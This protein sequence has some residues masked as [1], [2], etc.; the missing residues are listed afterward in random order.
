MSTDQS[1][2]LRFGLALIASSFFLS[3]VFCAALRRMA[4]RWGLLDRPGGH[5]GHRVPTPLGGGVAIWLAIMIVLSACG[6][7]VL[8]GPDRLPEAIARHAGGLRQRAGELAW[9]VGLSTV[10]MV[11]GFIDD[12]KNLHWKPRLAIQVGCAAAV[13][14]AAGVRI[15]LFGPFTHPLLGGAVTVLWIVALTNAFNMLDNMDG[16]A[17]SVGLIAALIFGAAQA[18]VG[19]LFAPAVLL[20]VVGA[21]AGF[22]VHN[23]APARLFMGDA[24]SNF[25]GFLL[26]SLTVAGS[27]FHEG[28]ASPF[29]VLAPLLVMAVPLYDMTSVILIR[30]S[31]GRSPFQGDRRHFSHRLVARGLTPPQ[32]VWTIDLV[33]LACGLGAL[34]LHRLDAWGAGLVLAQ[35]GCLLGIVAILEL[36]GNRSE[37]TLGH[38]RRETAEALERETGRQSD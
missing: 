9:I 5:K 33:T 38:A 28:V 8:F 22:L 26:G 37:Q 1:V 2:L 11:M 27:F 19:S 13:V 12:R 35:T 21:L 15:T 17:A 14:A 34:L 18:A 6:L 4:P 23:H 25:L 10:M 16:L 20:I 24:G 29:S 31:E 3:V 7:L 30:L 36:S 32:A